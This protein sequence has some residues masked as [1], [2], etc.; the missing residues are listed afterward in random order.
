MKKIT[1]LAS[2]FMIQLIVLL[3]FAIALEISGTGAKDITDKFAVAA[4][5]T[6]DP[7]DSRVFYGLNKTDLALTKTDINK[8]N[9][10]S[11]FLGGLSPNKVYYFKVKS[12]SSN[13]TKEDDNGGNM[14]SFQTLSNDSVPPYIETNVPEY[15]NK[16]VIDIFGKT[17]PMTLVNLYVNGIKIRKSD[18]NEKGEFT[19]PSVELSTFITNK[20]K[21]DAFDSSN[22]TASKNFST[23]VDLIQP[24]ITLPALPELTK[25][26][27]LVLQGVISEQAF[28]EISLNEELVFGQSITN[29]SQVL[30]LKEGINK[31]RLRA[32]DRAG[33]VNVKEA[34]VTLDTKPPTFENLDPAAG[35]FFYEGATETNIKG[36]T[37]PFAKV[38]LYI[39]KEP[40]N[41]PQFETTADSEG[42]FKFE[43]IDLEGPFF[44]GFGASGTIE[45]SGYIPV[46]SAETREQAGLTGANVT[47]QEERPVKLIFVGKDAVG[48]EGK[49]EISYKIGTCYS[50]GMNWGVQ[51]IIE[52]Q[53]PN[54]L[55][56]ERMEEGTELVSAIFNLTYR[57][58]GANPQIKSIRF[59][60]ACDPN[61][62]YLWADARYN[63]S[64]KILPSSPSILQSNSQKTTWYIRY[65]LD[66]YAGFANFSEDMWKDLSRQ[67]IFPLKVKIEYSHTVPGVNGTN[68]E[69]REFQT[70]CINL[71][72]N[73]DTSRIDPRDVLPDWLLEDGTKFLNESIMKLNDLVEKVNVVLKYTAIACLVGFALKIITI[74]YRRWQSWMDFIQDKTP[75]TEEKDKCPTP[76]NTASSKAPVTSDA[77]GKLPDKTTQADLTNTEL[78]NRCPNAFEAWNTEYSAYKAYR[79]ACDRFLCK[80]TPAR[81]TETADISV[82]R[83]RIE[84]SWMCRNEQ[85][86]QG[87]ILRKIPPDECTKKTG[88]A[89]CWKYEESYYIYK[90][91]QDR[92]GGYV[93]LERKD[94]TT[95]YT[96]AGAQK[97]LQVTEESGNMLLPN[98]KKKC[99]ATCKNEMK[100][101]RG[102]C[103]GNES[104]Q[105]ITDPNN[106]QYYRKDHWFAPGTVGDCKP[107]TQCVCIGKT[108]PLGTSAS[109]PADT[110]EKVNGK[111]SELPK[112]AEPWDYRYEKVGYAYNPFKYYQGRDQTA[113]FG[114]NN[115]IFK[116]EAYL[117]PQDT[118]PAFQCL[119]ISQI[120]NRIILLRNIM[121]GLYN[122]LM[123]IKTTG[124]ADAG[125]CKEIFTQYICKWIYRLITYFMKGCVPWAGTGKDFGIGD[126]VK[127]G[128]DSIWGGVAESQK[129]I[130]ADY[131]SAAMR[132]FLGV[133]DEAIANKICLG[134]LTGEWGWDLESFMDTAYSAPF[135][136]SARAFP[137]DREFL[138]WNP[139]NGLGTYEYRVAWMIAP[140]CELETYTLSLSC[141]TDDEFFSYDGLKCEQE[142][143][144]GNDSSP[145]G[146]DC[147]SIA[148]KRQAQNQP[149]PS[150]II[151]TS[152][153]IPQGIFQDGSTH[154]TVDAPYRYDNVKI[155]VYVKNT[156]DYE[157]C[158]PEKNRAGGN[159]GVFYTPI[160]DATTYDILA[161]RWDV[162]GGTF[163]C[164]QGGLLWEEKGR[165]YFGD[166]KCKEG[167]NDINCEDKAFYVNSDLT[168]N[169]VPVFVQSQRQC[170]FY[171]LKNGYGQVLNPDNQV[172]SLDPDPTNPEKWNAQTQPLQF[173]TIS[174]P[175]FTSTAPHVEITPTGSGMSV[176][177][178]TRD[179]EIGSTHSIY[180]K[181]IDDT[182]YSYII[183]AVGD[184]TPADK[185]TA[186]IVGGMILKFSPLL[187]SSDKCTEVNAGDV[188]C[189]KFE[190]KLQSPSLATSVDV[191]WNL[192]LEL[193]YIPANK[194]NCEESRAE[195]VI[196][197]QGLA[198]K[199]DI[200]LN[201]KSK[202]E[203]ESKKCK[204]GGTVQYRNDI[205]CDCDGDERTDG[206]ND[207]DGKT[208]R[209]CAEGSCHENP[210]CS[211][212]TTVNSLPCDC[213]WDGVID[214]DPTTNQEIECKG[215]YCIK[216][217]GG[218]F[219]QD[220]RPAVDN[221]PKLTITKIGGK[222]PPLEA[223]VV[224][225]VA[226]I[227]A[228]TED[229]NPG[230]TLKVTVDGNPYNGD[231]VSKSDDGK[232][233]K[234]SVDL[235]NVLEKG[236]QYTI[237]ITA[238]DSAGKPSNTV[239]QAVTFAGT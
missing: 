175:Q 130:L 176:I 26:T 91:L 13:G 229:D 3:P 70:T 191:P 7:A 88:S 90:P 137:A 28:L 189:R 74:I 72:F 89:D 148:N 43:N 188:P 128:A 154:V 141:V 76:G 105:K 54:T 228:T 165:A 129:D 94:L 222:A 67:M 156:A 22:N 41:K 119:C 35:S 226:I 133:G 147:R 87:A 20:I 4:W 6:N 8:V 153:S 80:G 48:Q 200:K 149:G 85:G 194:T 50:G 187:S 125:V 111:E 73:V 161:C 42:K 86:T 56:P 39:D 37:E 9:N 186:V 163:N 223:R 177:R 117:N 34:S 233:I 192:H 210:R 36:K 21:I 71:A 101:D 227:T 136:T 198:Q 18:P 185:D 162:V 150:Q 157:K 11:V 83:Q 113:C 120:R 122:C 232:T 234:W 237:T 40:D 93:I 118:I 151:Y 106:K 110:L 27:S 53:S 2:V 231:I 112:G 158:I 159:K 52:Y 59:E 172:L 206:P 168:I 196:V 126:Y 29:F 212:G 195:D 1:R 12:V 208:R 46:S 124:E 108:K 31:I 23:T 58:T 230:T 199:K 181:R 121:Q 82:V 65:N 169:S 5:Q 57:G 219:C 178:S 81:W 123:Q 238:T 103:M 203:A 75:G 193:R 160:H 15:S 145:G 77:D 49:Q 139:S 33:N 164:N 143:V 235:K 204:M 207:C 95:S 60:K 171:E 180:L 98:G 170:L 155:T 179:V 217:D 221:P 182:R 69:T 16:A 131:D 201:V 167:E 64:C 209:Y 190:I 236:I 202:T 135:Y 152:R 62:K 55:S 79:W 84:S 17:E 144:H 220:E 115:L 61:A 225:T 197:Y 109:P 24:E 213:N 107:G 142:E 10:H 100:A 183:D 224:M 19:F 44:A 166:I 32:I 45:K 99:D 68:N 146:C 116:N 132:D 51:N 214:K 215:K 218:Y 205:A 92:T 14:Y 184:W 102:E 47:K 66:R 134:A 25:N 63:I 96:P 173:G 211:V 174:A 216:Q 140:G 114:Q 127:A 138:T 78:K 104:A 239:I 30:S 38:L 97:E